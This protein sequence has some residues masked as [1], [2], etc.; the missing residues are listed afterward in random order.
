MLLQP[1]SEGAQALAGVLVGVRGDQ[2]GHRV[3]VEGQDL[4]VHQGLRLVAY[5]I[6]SAVI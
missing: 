5:T 1:V 4:G 2:Q 3:G 6:I